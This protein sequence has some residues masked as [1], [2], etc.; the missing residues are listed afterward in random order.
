MESE[1]RFCKPEAEADDVLMQTTETA[2]EM[3]ESMYPPRLGTRLDSL[4]LELS[5]RYRYTPPELSNY[6]REDRVGA[7]D[8]GTINC[9]GISGSDFVRSG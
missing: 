2:W 3:S 4:E 6:K 5:V 9:S 8:F 7:Y 1:T